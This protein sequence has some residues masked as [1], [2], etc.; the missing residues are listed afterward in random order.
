MADRETRMQ[1]KEV[2]AF[3]G[4][5]TDTLRFYEQKGII[6][7]VKRDKN[8]Y[9]VYTDFD[10]NWLYIVLNLKRA[11]LSL[12]K[13]AEFTQLSLTT[14]SRSLVAQKLL[15]Q[16]QLDEINKRLASLQDMR[17]VLEWKLDHFDEHFKELKNGRVAVKEL[18]KE[19]VNFRK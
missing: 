18:R 12:D 19:W 1:S 7:Q 6:P 16:E 14:Q 8:G 11:G 17:A 5:S 2:A 4:L 9:R 10:L 13:I 15:L 3:F